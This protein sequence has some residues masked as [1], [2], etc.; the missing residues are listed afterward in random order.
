MGGEVVLSRC[1]QHLSGPRYFFAGMILP[2]LGGNGEMGCDRLFGGG[3]LPDYREQNLSAL[4][5]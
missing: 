2:R 4:S 5:V 1:V 3:E